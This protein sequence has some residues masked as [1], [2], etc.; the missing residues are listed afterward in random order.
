[1]EERIKLWTLILFQFNFLSSNYILLKVKPLFFSLPPKPKEKI[2]IWTPLTSYATLLIVRKLYG[3]YEKRDKKNVGR[4]FKKKRCSFIM[5]QTKILH[6]VPSYLLLSFN[7][8]CT[9]GK[10]SHE[11]EF[12]KIFWQNKIYYYKKDIICKKNKFWIIFCINV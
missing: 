8:F 9:S 2:Y 7:R 3:W 4:I 11:N 5:L 10:L 12:L 1:M 6:G